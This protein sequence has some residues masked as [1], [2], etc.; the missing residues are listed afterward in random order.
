MPSFPVFDDPA[1]AEDAR[2]IVPGVDRHGGVVIYRQ[3]RLTH[4]GINGEWFEAVP[5][6]DPFGV[7]PSDD[8]G[9]GDEPGDATRLPAR[10][11]PPGMV[12]GS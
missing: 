8:E 7:P 12:T 6:P 5:L 11:N 9:S 4:Y 2:T 1:G 3:G 10:M